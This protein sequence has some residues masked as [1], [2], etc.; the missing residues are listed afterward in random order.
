MLEVLVMWNTLDH[1]PSSCM[2]EGTKS[3]VT[4]N[5]VPSC[6]NLAMLLPWDIVICSSLYDLL[7]GK[8]K[9][10]VLTETARNW[11]LDAA[12]SAISL[13]Q[14]RTS[15]YMDVALLFDVAFR[16]K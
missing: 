15:I 8:V 10:P 5:W 1:A 11:S 12:V 2:R 4:E 13:A 16:F 9:L 6:E 3:K 7:A 14:P